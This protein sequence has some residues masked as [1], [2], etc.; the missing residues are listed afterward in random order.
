MRILIIISLLFVF[1]ACTNDIKDVKKIVE[2]K[3][4]KVE[5]AYD[6]KILYSDSA[7]VKVRIT[8]PTLK[9]Y[10]SHGDTYDEF[11]D[12]LLVEFLDDNKRV[13]SWLEAEYAIR[14]DRD[15]KIYVENNVVLFNK[16]EDKL[17]TDELIWDEANEELY[18]NKPVKIAQPS[19]GDTSFGF[20]FKA[21]QSF[22]RFEIHRK[23]S[24]IK[25]VDEFSKDFDKK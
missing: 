21:D 23:F 12:G 15:K 25:N 20:G 24:S 6:V 4:L 10:S 2:D 7:K 17:M 5:I 1:F 8:S 11:P 22:T 9:R 14:K 19:V 16:K 3:D 13:K 18:T